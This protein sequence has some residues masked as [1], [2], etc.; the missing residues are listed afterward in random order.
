M[1]HCSVGIGCQVMLLR[2]WS[3][4]ASA[5]EVRKWHSQVE[6]GHGN[7]SV[8]SIV[9]KVRRERQHQWI[10]VFPSS[11]LLKVVKLSWFDLSS[12]LT[13]TKQPNLPPTLVRS[14]IRR[15][16]VQATDA[17]SKVKVRHDTRYSN[18][19]RYHAMEIAQA[20]IHVSSARGD[21][22]TKAVR[23]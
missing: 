20:P 4:E 14:K 11:D 8:L 12:N 22:F 3:G 19:G 18:L 2:T 7:K 23:L 21:W 15:S 16:H 1:S 5:V 13:R 9:E 6:I 10:Q 17:I